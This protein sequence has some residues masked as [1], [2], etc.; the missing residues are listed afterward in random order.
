M[1]R[2]D[3]LASSAA[4]TGA[5]AC[6]TLSVDPPSTPSASATAGEASTPITAAKAATPHRIRGS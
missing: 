1:N 5:A 4:I 6:V 3:F 2:R